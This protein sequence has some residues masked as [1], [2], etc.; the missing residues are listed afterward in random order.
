MIVVFLHERFSVLWT[1]AKRNYTRL[2]LP[3]TPEPRHDKT[4][5]M[6]VRPAKD[7]SAWASAQCDQSLHCPHE[8]SLGPLPIERTVK[9]DQTGWMPGLIRVFAGQ[10]FILLVLSCR[11]SPINNLL[12]L[13]VQS[14]A[15]QICYLTSVQVLPVQVL[16]ISPAMTS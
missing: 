12:G 1:F 3:K 7:S 2:E 5:K 9:T 11:G 10:T 15:C 8:D 13:L 4:N 16:Q 6:S 14:V